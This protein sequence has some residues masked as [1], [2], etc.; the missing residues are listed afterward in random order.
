MPECEWEPL[1]WDIGPHRSGRYDHERCARQ[2]P[3][4]QERRQPAEAAAEKAAEPEGKALEIAA[5]R[6]E[7]EQLNVSRCLRVNLLGAE[8]DLL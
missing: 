6:A 2:Q 7:A 4:E 1:E 8:T 3:R 5:R